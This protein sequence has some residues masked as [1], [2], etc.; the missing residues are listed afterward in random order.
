M[1]VQRVCAESDARVCKDGRG[2]GVGCVVVWTMGRGWMDRVGRA[3]GM[4]VVD[5]GVD[6]W[7]TDWQVGIN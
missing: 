5:G 2:G 6:V 7:V 1:E 3:G 4:R